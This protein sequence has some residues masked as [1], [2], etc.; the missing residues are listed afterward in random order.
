M[1]ETLQERQ[2]NEIE[3]LKAIF[4]PSEFRD[5]REGDVWNTTRPPDIVLTVTPQQ[6][7]SGPAE[8][9]AQ[10]DLHVICDD[11]YPEKVPK[12]NLEHS[13][14]L[15]TQH[16]NQ[17]SEELVS[18]ANELVGEVMIYE[19][20]QHAQKFLIAF[21]K[22]QY[23]SFYDEM[24]ARQAQQ[25]KQKQL[26]R[27]QEQDKERQSLKEHI[28]RKQLALKEEERQRKE[29][30]Q[31]KETVINSGSAAVNQSLKRQRAQSSSSSGDRL[32]CNHRGTKL[33]KFSD[34]QIRI[35]QCL[36]HSNRGK[37]VYAGQDIDSGELVV[38]SQWK[39]K[40]ITPKRKGSQD[41]IHSSEFTNIMKQI[42][43]MEQEMH[44]LQKLSHPGIVRYRGFT[45]EQLSDHMMISI[46]Q[47]FADGVNLAIFL[48]ESICVGL[49]LLHHIA[50]NALE[51]LSFLHRNNIVHRDLRHSSIYILQSGGVTISNYSLDSK[52][53]EFVQGT[54][55][56]DCGL[57]LAM[58]RGAKKG[59]VFR[60]GCLLLSLFQ[61]SP[62]TA[63][64]PVP[65]SNASKEFQEF[66]QKC[67]DRNEQDRW[68]AEQLL[69]H[70]YVHTYLERQI[71]PLRSDAKNGL[72]DLSS[73]AEGDTKIVLPDYF[74]KGS[75]RV[76][77]E[78][79]VLKWL[80]KGAFGDVLKVKN[81]LDARVYALKRI[82][83]NP[84]NKTLI[85]R[86]TREC[87]LLSRLNHE[88][89][90][91]YYNSWIESALVAPNDEPDTSL[92]SA[93]TEV[94]LGQTTEENAN[95]EK[96]ILANASVEWSVSYEA[97][98][99][100]YNFGSDS[101]SSD[102]DEDAGPWAAIFP[103]DQSSSIVFE[104]EVQ[105]EELEDQV[106]SQAS[107]SRQEHEPKEIQFLYIQMEFCE[108]STLRNAIDSG[109]LYSDEQR[110]WRLFR[111]IVEGLAHIHQ[112]GMIHR[113][114]KP[115]NVF[116]DIQDHVKIGDFGLATSKS[117]APIGKEHLSLVSPEISSKDFQD[118]GGALTGHVGT[119]LYS[120]PELNTIAGQVVFY[121]Q[122][123][124][125][126]SLGII[127]FE[128]CHAPL[129][130][131]MER[132]KVLV[133]LRQQ[134]INLPADFSKEEHPQQVHV[135]KWLLNHDPSKRPS[136]QELLKAECLLPLQHE[137]VALQ[138]ILTNAF[139]NT[140][141]KVYKHLV[142]SFMAQEVPQA[143][144]LTFDMGMSKSL[145]VPRAM[146]AVRPMIEK[147][148]LK[149]GAVRLSSPMLIPK[150]STSTRV[151]ETSTT[152]T[153]MTHSGSVVTLPH[154][155]RVPFAR[156]VAWSG[157]TTSL[158]RY[159]IEKVFRERRVFGVHPRELYECAFDI[160]SPNLSFQLAEAELLAILSEIVSEF[161]EDIQG[162]V[163]RLNHT[164]LVKAVLLNSGID[165]EK[166]DEYI[167]MIHELKDSNKPNAKLQNLS[168]HSMENLTT[169]LKAEA[170]LSQ[171]HN[172]KALAKG[173]GTTANLAKEGLK[174][175]ES[176]ISAAEL[177]GV[178]CPMIVS[179]GLVLDPNRYSGFICQLCCENP[180]SHHRRQRDVIA[181]GG[182][183]SHLLSKYRDVLENAQSVRM[184]PIGGSG[185]SV[186]L[187]RLAAILQQQ[188]SDPLILSQ[189]DTVI[190][191][192]GSKVLQREAPKLA[193]E[194]WAAGVKT[195]LVQHVQGI[196]EAEALVKELGALYL[197]LLKDSEP[198]ITRIRTWDK[199]RFQ[200][201]KVDLADVTGWLT[202]KYNSSEEAPDTNVVSNYAN[203]SSASM[204]VGINAGFNFH[205]ATN[206]KLAHNT[207]RRYEGLI[208][209][210]LAHL[211][212]FLSPKSVVEVVAVS[213]EGNIV[214]S[215][216]ANL[217][218]NGSEDEFNASIS[219]VVE[220]YGKHRKYL[221]Q[222]CDKLFEIKF[223]KKLYGI[224]L[225]SLADNVYRTLF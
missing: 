223:E 122:K 53:G 88:N 192:L 139:E 140:Q 213:V 49:D 130:T 8:I 207:R 198:N 138:E 32:T 51:S 134:D 15:S 13:K 75:S 212:K 215:L 203:Q 166:H 176:V 100:F 89:V 20:A 62:I 63:I 158:K 175:L 85:R 57:P 224:V 12:I 123:V 129:G 84:R 7:S 58:G 5:L 210:H 118:D 191:S 52:I 170:P 154:D 201:K 127:F 196:E 125:I 113:D 6:G 55:R 77:T 173:R 159:T 177:L 151:K 26:L 193:R 76:H 150:S 132:V 78:F 105:D 44:M 136:A 95:L 10:I 165:E 155:L 124:D 112:Q 34:R 74:G 102:E 56:V 30:I 82:K 107:G 218:I 41:E 117:S 160:V 184:V 87:K 149:H 43:S 169:V 153:M 39:V 214:K 93:T 144:D 91:R 188:C 126:Y 185:I 146:S 38:V 172:L 59:D 205:F 189:A 200:D 50:K 147:I 216:A 66:L 94:G 47:E 222:V 190:S 116:L 128:M 54:E 70:P 18:L 161:N 187:E 103:P 183:Y 21:N 99:Q 35:G 106:D 115:V 33:V 42:S 90:V 73:E 48:Q 174:Y 167:S 164:S 225:Y 1:S 217:E 104:G 19:L 219:A 9:Y 64:L 197:V 61:G 3:A 11:K 182:N 71:S 28:Q 162:A 208:A 60:F 29:I 69:N 119:A 204:N 101:S 86:I 37:I 23:Q 142:S 2:E 46:L 96:S 4:A 80:G 79:E 121:N 137:D 163:I 168:H 120:A 14:G 45:Y 16:I 108:K 148:F 72:D 171:M 24:Q 152:V 178:K 145:A 211:V 141:S 81:K 194:L 98:P 110:V 133:A 114:L 195:H 206:E 17:L 31:E 92:A 22:P 25:E 181:V 202:R 143:E 199:D 109:E 111:E 40:C 180:T 97:R 220:K 65:P 135:I 67:L 68:S 209:G 221:A 179:P 156:F 131:T 36:G 186:S 157:I 27:Q 83:L